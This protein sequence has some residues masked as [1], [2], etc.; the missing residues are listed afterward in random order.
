ML[1]RSVRC[2]RVRRTDADAV[3]ALL[4]A[5]GDT[6]P[7]PDR[8]RLHR[9]RQ[10]VADLGSDCYVAVADEQVVGMVHVTYARHLLGRQLAT[11]ELLLA[12]DPRGGDAATALADLVGARARQRGCRFIDWREPA[13][14]EAM[15]AFA[16]H[17]GA[18]PVAERL[19]VEIPEPAE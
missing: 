4:E 3:F 1:K 9:F 14:N 18:R 19:R 8:A 15:R 13:R 12:A 5:A 7:S 10:L 17:L 16:A 11:V 6:I 2:R